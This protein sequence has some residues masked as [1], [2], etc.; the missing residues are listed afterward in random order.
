MCR[1]PD[2]YKQNT[3][4]ITNLYES[5]IYKQHYNFSDERTI[6]YNMISCFGFLICNT[7]LT[8]TPCSVSEIEEEE[9]EKEEVARGRG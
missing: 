9:E 1:N 4:G 6:T 3:R 2:I 8:L 5:D 7:S